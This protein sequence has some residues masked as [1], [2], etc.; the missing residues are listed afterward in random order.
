[1]NV[2]WFR[3]DLRLQDNP[4]LS[5]AL[6]AGNVRAIYIATPEQWK[7]HHGSAIQADF[8]ERHLNHLAQQLANM[9]IELEVLQCPRFKD[10]QTLLL[11]YCQHHQVQR[12]FANQEL[13][14]NEVKTDK[15]LISCNIPLM[16]LE[17]DVILPKGSIVNLQNQMFKVFTPFKKAW[18]AK[19]KTRWFEC[20][21][22]SNSHQRPIS[23]P[24]P[25]YL[26]YD[27]K[28][29]T[30]WPLVGEHLNTSFQSFLQ[31][32]LCLYS[33]NRDFP[34]IK[35]TSGLSPYLAI[36]A[37]SPKVILKQLLERHPQLLD[38]PSDPS[39]SWLNEL[40]WREFYRHLMYHFPKLS[41]NYNFK[42]QYDNLPW[43]N[44]Q[45]AFKDW[46]HGNT[47]YPIVDAAMRQLHDIGWMHNRLR[48]IVASFL[49]KHLLID[50]RLGQNYFSEQLIDNDLAANNGGWQWSAGTGCDAQPYFRIF[51]PISQ[52]QKFDPQGTFI[53][54]Y[55][56]ELNELS[57]KHIHFPHEQLNYSLFSQNDLSNKYWPPI[58]NHAQ[59]RAQALDFYKLNTRKIA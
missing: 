59:A 24:K 6:V 18:L 23:A 44:N 1:M 55:L 31:N 16:L 14:F 34:G 33:Q 2:V 36:G 8:I 22:L 47:G 46:C 40:I 9:G 27:K 58:V 42:P 48:M 41:R 35:G 25:I 56:P 45:Q 43:V 19:L 28:D 39:F 11:E 12:I 26:P 5:A 10:I 57:D 29:S 54:H 37:V 50:W 17:A 32:K 7:E 21:P 53:R 51:N 49:T 30:Q 52:S 15:Q 38:S 20:V 13:E 4:A 3:K